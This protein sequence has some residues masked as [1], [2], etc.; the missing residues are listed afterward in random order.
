MTMSNWTF[1]E[2][3]QQ[4]A[5]GLQARLPPAMCD[6]HA[7]LWRKADLKEPVS[8][9]WAEGPAEA[10]VAVWRRHIERQVGASRLTGG[11]LIPN[12]LVGDAVAETIAFVCEQIV[13]CCRK[14]PNARLI[15]AHAARG[16]HAPNTVQGLAALCGLNN[17]WFDTAGVCEPES[18]VAIL[19]AFGPRRLM[20]DTDVPAH[21]ARQGR[22]VMELW[23]EHGRRHGL[24]IT[25]GGYP[26]LPHFA[27]EHPEAIAL[28]TLYTQLMLDHGF[29]AGTKFYATLAHDDSVVERYGQAIDAV[30]AGI[31]S[32]LSDG[33]PVVDRLR[34]PLAHEGFRRLTN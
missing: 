32:T 14:Y 30:L 25:V 23:S 1:C 4:I 2:L 33:G 18:F 24:P 11:L 20:R 13:G 10:G 22:H 15:L 8:G 29:L 6:A 5:D 19:N 26:C 21:V 34:G 27:F 31:A 16:F 12:P 3:D 28:R 9:L 17:V 7:H